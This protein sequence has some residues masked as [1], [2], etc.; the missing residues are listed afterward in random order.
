M[1]PRL[2][3][4]PYRWRLFLFVCATAFAART[5]GAQPTDDDGAS[6]ETAYP[7]PI[8]FFRIQVENDA[9][10]NSG[11]SYYTNGLKA[12][13]RFDGG[14]WSQ[15]HPLLPFQA[16]RRRVLNVQY[17]LSISQLMFTPT[18]I[19]DTDLA[20]L[21]S[22]RP[23]SGWLSLGIGE[24]YSLRGA[25]FAPSGSSRIAYQVQVGPMGK[26][27]HAAE[28]Q[29]NWHSFDRDLSGCDLADPNCAPRPPMGW[30]LNYTAGGT[31]VSF[32]VLGESEVG[33]SLRWR[34][35]RRWTGSALG[36]RGLLGATI[37][38][39]NVFVQG[40][41]DGR[42]RFG[43]IG[44]TISSGD[45][46][47]VHMGPTLR[48]YDGAETVSSLA[49]P[50]VEK[51]STQTSASPAPPARRGLVSTPPALEPPPRDRP[52]RFVEVPFPFELYAFVAATGRAV[53]YN[54][55]LDR[56]VCTDGP[57]GTTC[58]PSTIDKRHFVSDLEYGF[59]VRVRFIDVAYAHVSRSAEIAAPS[60]A[61][62][63]HDFGVVRLTFLYH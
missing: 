36:V 42:V 62:V 34:W 47:G 61:N 6:N 23:Y 28:V 20:I 53:A 59:A 27:S 55:F 17:D 52:T 46:G 2:R 18:H 13:T 26:A 40:A 33:V 8:E 49:P 15:A 21:R 16:L 31:G 38:G 5:A 51:T 24:S 45:R 35:L 3:F 57:G 19:A 41:L 48:R 54:A 1:A 7:L 37:D 30:T 22:D 58:V 63:R 43:L 50:P 9:F 44:E 14:P 25:P 39:G 12:E 32:R 29:K 4:L 10:T 60:P 11:D 56:D